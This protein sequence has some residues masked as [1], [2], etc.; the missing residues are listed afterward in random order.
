VSET[1]RVL[2]VEDLPTDAELSEREVGKGAG[3]VR[4]PTGGDPRGR[5]SR[6]WMS[7]VPRSSCLTTGCPTSMV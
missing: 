5:I 6:H 4:V 7:F 3:R 2:I 1:I